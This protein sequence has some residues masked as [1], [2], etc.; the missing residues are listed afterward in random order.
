MYKIAII[1]PMYNVEKYIQEMIEAIIKQ[2]IGF[3]NIQL[4]LVDDFSKDATANICKTYIEKYDNIIYK[5]VPQKS[6]GPGKARNIGINL[7]NSQYVMFVDGDDL[8]QENACEKLYVAIEEQKADCVIS[9]YK[10]MNENG[11]KWEEPIF[12]IQKYNKFEVNIQDDTKSIFIL[13][14]AVW[15]KIYR[16]EFIKE[17]NL[18]FLEDCMAEDAYFCLSTYMEA[19]KIYYIPEVTYY[20]RI[21]NSGNLSI[22]N[23]YTS[24]YFK[25]Y[26]K[27]YQEIYRM[28]NQYSYYK[29]RNFFFTKAIMFMIYKIVDA[30]NYLE[31]KEIKEIFEE[32]Q[33][34]FALPNREGVIITQVYTNKILDEIMNK[35]YNEAIKL[36]KFFAEI[37]KDLPKEINSKLSI[38][39]DQAY[40]KVCKNGE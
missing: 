12:D 39:D 19:R 27:G 6:G 26:N 32:M 25:E 11:I 16:T 21:R 40:I 1:V 10:N 22:S 31:Q 29:L 17:K 34:M 33:W 7:A 36:C 9:N 37:R 30:T 13:E 23:N 5:K 15:N 18:H 4:I 28:L 3:Q 20:Y 14:S 8:L 35:K 38:Q 2:S 24:K